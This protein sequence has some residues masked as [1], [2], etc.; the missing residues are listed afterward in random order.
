LIEVKPKR[1]IYF[2]I[3]WDLY[4]SSL[5]GE[6]YIWIYIFILLYTYWNLY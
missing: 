5:I 3:C 6:P 2:I 4:E 1:K